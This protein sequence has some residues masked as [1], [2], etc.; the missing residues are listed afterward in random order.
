MD[1]DDETCVPCPACEICKLCKGRGKL[2]CR[3]CPI[4]H[5][6]SCRIC[7]A[8]DL[9]HGTH[10]VTAGKRQEWSSHYGPP[11]GAA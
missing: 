7:I 8:C 4:L 11:K 10:V 5:S 9:C 6:I 1:D 3:Q 2:I